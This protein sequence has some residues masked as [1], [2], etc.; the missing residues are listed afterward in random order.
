MNTRQVYSGT[1]AT[2]EVVKLQCN[3]EAFIFVDGTSFTATLQH[4]NKSIR[5]TGGGELAQADDADFSDVLPT[6]TFSDTA[7][8][9]QTLGGGNYALKFS[10]AGASLIITVTA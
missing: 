6:V 2:D 10:A 8:Y 1:P 9:Q 3:S 7:N 4:L 5:G